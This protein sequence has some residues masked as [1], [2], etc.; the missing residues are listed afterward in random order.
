MTGVLAGRIARRVFAVPEEPG[1]REA[2]A[3]FA[4]R[5]ATHDT[6]RRIAESPSGFDRDSWQA[7][8]GELG[9]AGIGVPEE[10]GG[11]GM[12]FAELAVVMEELGST[13]LPSPLLASR[14]LAVEMLSRCAVPEV[15]PTLRA[16][17]AGD[18]IGT[19]AFGTSGRRWRPEDVGVSVRPAERAVVGVEPMGCLLDGEASYVLDGAIADVLVVVGVDGGSLTLCLVVGTEPGLSVRPMETIDLTRRQAKVRFERC[20]ARMIARGASAV[21]IVGQVLDRAAIALAAEQVGGAQRC[22][23]M[24]V[25]YAKQRVQFGRPIGTFQAV[26]HACADVLLELDAARW[27][28]R[29]AARAVD[30]LPQ[31][32]PVLAPL[33][34]A[35]CSQM[36]ESAAR[37]CVQIHGGIGFTWEFSAQ[38]YLKRALSSK[39]L[40]GTPREHREAL[41]NRLG[42]DS[43]QRGER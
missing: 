10:C 36:Y 16:L 14:V 40:F 7:L 21:E 28:V 20:R 18:L 29:A 30:H 1:V 15:R 32:V 37:A 26:K 25:A 31:E 42:L 2:V 4:A 12:G 13:L 39:A 22:L 17:V 34:K 5:D 38:L 3:Q 6:V 9:A 41:L 19:V 11:V 27:T 35:H 8:A 33:V 23:D 24:A 43:T